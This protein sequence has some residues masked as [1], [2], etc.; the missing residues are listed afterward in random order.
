MAHASVAIGSTGLG[1][2]SA[3]ARAQQCSVFRAW[4]LVVGCGYANFCLGNPPASGDK[5][6]EQQIPL[7]V[8]RAVGFSSRGRHLLQQRSRWAADE[9]HAG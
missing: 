2:A 8:R 5:L 4:V 1:P 6:V 9:L 7:Q 3:R